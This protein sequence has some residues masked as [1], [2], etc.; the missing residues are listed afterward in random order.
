MVGC[1]T[2]WQEE[3]VPLCFLPFGTKANSLLRLEGG[4]AA[5]PGLPFASSP[6]NCST[7]KRGEDADVAC[8]GGGLFPSMCEHGEGR[9]KDQSALN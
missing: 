3:M 6:N 4:D 5:R 8:R 2:A 7:K 1:L 9:E